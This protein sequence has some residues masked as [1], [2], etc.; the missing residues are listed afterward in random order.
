MTRLVKSMIEQQL[1]V[2]SNGETEPRMRALDTWHAWNPAAGFFPLFNK[3][4][5]QGARSRAP[6][7]SSPSECPGPGCAA[8]AQD[9]SSQSV[10]GTAAATHH[11]RVSGGVARST[12]VAQLRLG[13]G[14]ARR[15]Q[16]TAQ[17]DVGS[18]ARRRRR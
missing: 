7:E 1:L 8:G 10:A 2:S 18:P 14:D 17:P 13:T 16:H 3:R 6:G 15:H 11:R 12:H 5:G 9:I 4:R